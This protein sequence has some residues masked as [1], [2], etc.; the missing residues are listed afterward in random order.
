MYTA[1]RPSHTSLSAMMLGWCASALSASTSAD[2][3]FFS[4]LAQL[5]VFHARTVLVALRAVLSAAVYG[6]L[7]PVLVAVGA[8]IR[9][10]LLHQ[11]EVLWVVVFVF[12]V[13]PSLTSNSVD[14]VFFFRSPAQCALL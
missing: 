8:R 4:L 5:P 9:G 6:G 3:V 1:L 11:D 10:A 12:D 14:H 2:A 7:V 13:S